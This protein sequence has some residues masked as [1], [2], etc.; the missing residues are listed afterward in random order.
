MLNFCFS[1]IYYGAEPL[2]MFRLRAGQSD[3][4]G[5]EHGKHHGLDEAYQHLKGRHE[6]A[7]NH[8]HTT[9]AEKNPDRLC[10]HEE[11]DADE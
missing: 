2:F 4:D 3:E 7:H 9:H 6:H 8:T 10:R 11:D 5:T 1:K